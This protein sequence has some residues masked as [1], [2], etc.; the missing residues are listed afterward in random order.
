MQGVIAQAVAS[1]KP[2]A[3]VGG[4]KPPHSCGFGS[5]RFLEGFWRLP[6][7]GFGGSRTRLFCQNA[8][9]GIPLVATVYPTSI[10]VLVLLAYSRHP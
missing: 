7:R 8:H 9:Q 6:C 3:G 5:L 1:G 2:F 10:D 4:G